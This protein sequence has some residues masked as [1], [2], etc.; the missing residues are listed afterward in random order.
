MLPPLFRR[1]WVLAVCVYL[2]AGTGLTACRPEPDAARSIALD[3]SIAPAPP[4]VGPA[5]LAFTLT[6]TTTAA[7]VTGA[8][9]RVEV[10]MTHPGMQPVLGTAAEV[11]PGRYEAPVEFTMGGDWFVLI[12]A[13]LPDGRTLQRQIDVEG[14]A[15]P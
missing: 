2:L 6:D 11:S 8:V 12:D 14:V 7:P 13:T 15:P 3:W 10:N 9:A 5:T 1:R 4:R